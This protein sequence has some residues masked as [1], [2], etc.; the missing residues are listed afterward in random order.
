MRQVALLRELHTKVVRGEPALIGSALQD[1]ANQIEQLTRELDIQKKV[2]ELA[3]IPHR[4][5]S[6][7]RQRA[8]R[9]NEVLRAALKDLSRAYVSMMETGRDRIIAMGGDCDPVDVMERGDPYLRKAME[10]LGE[11]PSVSQL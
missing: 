2:N 4:S 8:D 3:Y 1:A 7:S 5:L 6:D 9:E 10:A 11:S